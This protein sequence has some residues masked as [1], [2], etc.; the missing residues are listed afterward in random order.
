MALHCP[1]CNIPHP[2][3]DKGRKALKT[4]LDDAHNEVDIDEINRGWP[5]PNRRWA[6]CMQCR[7]HVTAW[8]SACV[9]HAK[10]CIQALNVE[11][12]RDLHY[13][14]FFS[15]TTLSN[16]AIAGAYV[17]E[18]AVADIRVENP[19]VVPAEN[20]ADI[21][22]V[23]AP[24]AAPNAPIVAANPAEVAV[25]ADAPVV[26]ANPRQAALNA[27]PRA[28]GPRARG[29]P[30]PRAGNANGVAQGADQAGPPVLAMHGFDFV[31][32]GEP[33]VVQL[34]ELDYLSSELSEGLYSM[35]PAHKSFFRTL[36]DTLLRIHLDPAGD[37]CMRKLSI[38]SILILPGLF[39][40][41]QRV[42]TDRLGDVLRELND[43]VS[44]VL[45]VLTRA[46]QTLLV[47]PRRPNRGPARLN[48]SKVDDLVKAQRIGA[49]MNALEANAEGLQARTKPLAELEELTA[50]FHPEGDNNDYVDNIHAPP[51]VAAA[52]FDTMELASAITKL[53]MGSAAGASGWTFHL[54]RSVYEGEARKVLAGVEAVEN[55]GLGLLK[56]FLSTITMGTVDPF[57]LRKLNTSRLAYIP[58]SNN[59]GD[60]PLAIGDSILRLLLRVL[61]AKYAPDV[62]RKLEPL[63]VAVGTSGGCEVMAAM[64]QHSFSHRN[65]TLTLDLHSAF[66]QVW[67]SAIAVGLR[68]HAPALLPIFKL[69]YGRP[70]ELR[71]NAKE[72]RAMLVGQSMRGCKQGDPLSMLYFAVAIHAWLRSVDTL[73]NERHAATAPE[74]IPFTIGYADDIALGGDPAVLCDCLPVISATLKDETGLIITRRKCKLLDAG[75]FVNPEGQDLGFPIVH[76]GTILVGVPIGTEAF[77]R[78]QSEIL[79]TEA[80]T[81]ARVVSETNLVSAQ[82]KFALLA[83][84]VNARPQYLCRNIRPQLIAGNLRDFDLAIDHALQSILG[85]NLE[86]TRAQLRGLPLS[87]GGCGIRRHGGSESIHAYNSRIKLVTEFLRNYNHGGRALLRAL[88][89][90][91]A[92][93]PIPFTHHDAIDNPVS[94]LREEHTTLLKI[95]LTNMEQ[96]FDGDMKAAW[97]R[98]G[99]HLAAADNSYTASGRFLLWSGGAD[100]RWQMTDNIF[101]SALR[102]RLCFPETNTPLMCPHMEL[103]H[104]AGLQVNLAHCFGHLSLCHPGTPR[105]IV[106][107]HDFIVGALFEL[108]KSTIPGDRPVPANVMAR[109]V[110]VGN[111]PNGDAIQA[112]IVMNHQQIRTVF[113]V[114]IVEPFN[115]HGLGHM[116]V[117]AAVAAAAARKLADYSTV[118]NQPGVLFVPFALDSNG[119]IGKHA[120]AYL[121]RLKEIN[122]TIGSRIK[123]FMQEVSHH[124]AKQS[125]IASEAGRAVALQAVWR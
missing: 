116:E 8:G 81:G 4:H 50:K 41:L 25:I 88:E 38:Y 120:T 36:V 96:E 24:P 42:K 47:Y 109:E 100:N 66:N 86:A 58:K 112:D 18:R 21:D 89:T 79:L 121:N 71:S 68:E 32:D 10:A 14:D 117:G 43:S 48:K 20:L 13:S 31:F 11:N 83:L 65:A 123:S 101:V 44:P 92:F 7:R 122:P 72:G 46:R 87:H 108:I 12:P 75:E 5:L 90:F 111:R 125:A 26:P 107:R 110:V 16:I 34:T 51:D 119:H 59:G 22:A 62:G 19:Q 29:I 91:S 95:V 124:L 55:I 73:V 103:H 15:A 49:L 1:V 104:P 67:R 54:L 57:V 113:D 39:V 93:E 94:S 17:I 115:R 6:K 98:S 99:M 85:A 97:V 61:N 82:A 102:K 45:A 63:Q 64:A 53:P 74:T 9:N 60:R 2:P 3:T 69:L 78:T 27:P 84:C 77:Q 30:R 23:L 56:R 118:T 106:N 37:A 28:R 80:A 52:S 40:R 33:S 114:V 35:H 105:A 76:D 70:S